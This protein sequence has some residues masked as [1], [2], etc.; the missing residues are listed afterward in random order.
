M[1]NIGHRGRRLGEREASWV[2]SGE[3]GLGTPL[4]ALDGFSGPLN[5]LLT[6]A[7]AQKV[8]LS[9]VSLTALV[10][11]L[12]A[13]LQQAPVTMP[14]GQKGDW[15]V[16]VAWLVQLRARLLLPPDA[17]A[18]QDAQAETGQL[19]EHLIALQAMQAVAN[20]LERR[21]QLGHDLFARGRPE[22]VGCSIDATHAVDVVEFFWASLVLFDDDTTAPE[23]TR[24]YQPQSFM[25]YAA[26]E[27][28]DRIRRRL[29]ETRVGGPLD[30]FLP[31]PPVVAESGPWRAL[32][33]RSAWSSTFI[34]SL[35]LARQGEVALRQE[36]S[37]VTIYIGA[38]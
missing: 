3:D 11:Q 36:D 19:R 30:R 32:R 18:L 24:P 16:M 38:I 26:A 7:R 1:D 35:E 33:K 31:D 9:A 34:A 2:P 14:L 25:L 27:A 4:L 21:P 17:P 5:H 8:D 6:L 15:V 29:A 23:T 22:I 37:F 10:G 12:E 28:R 20:W 13:A